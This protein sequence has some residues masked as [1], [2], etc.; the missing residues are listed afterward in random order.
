MI[1]LQN[2]M[3]TILTNSRNSETSY[4][5]RLFINITDKIN[6][7]SIDKPA[8]LSNFIKDFYKERKTINISNK[9]NKFWMPALAWNGES[10]LP[11]GSYSLSSIW[12]YLEYILKKHGG[13]IDNPSIHLYV[14]KVENRNKYG[15][16]T[17][18]YFE[19][20]TV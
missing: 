6:I 18:Y 1:K 8:P 20:L 17:E 19:L 7:K 4:P 12:D 15:L 13:N 9:S 11:D 14:N 16:Q 2:R 5:Q 10:Q 3:N